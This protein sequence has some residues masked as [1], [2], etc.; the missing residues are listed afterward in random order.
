MSTAKQAMLAMY[1]KHTVG[2]NC[3]DSMKFKP[4]TIKT[5]D[6]IV[7][8]FDQDNKYT[9]YSV[10]KVLEDNL[11][12]HRIDKLPYNTYLPFGQ[13]GI[14]TNCGVDTTNLLTIPKNDLKGKCSSFDNILCTLPLEI[15][16]D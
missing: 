14:F 7:Y 4:D 6:S 5:C 2:H 16:M 12:V 9:I 8:T 1:A 15:L 13:V 3:K 11:E 10:V